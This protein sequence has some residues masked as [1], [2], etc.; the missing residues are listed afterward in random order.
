MTVA[1]FI[2]LW[3]YDEFKFNTYHKNYNSIARVMRN[4]TLNGET[5]SLPYLPFPLGEELKTKYG[6]T[7]K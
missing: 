1:M 7:F 6:S 2:G 3:I 4:G 5:L